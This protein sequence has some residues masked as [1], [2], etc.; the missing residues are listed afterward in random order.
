MRVKSK[1]KHNITL[2]YMNNTT[3]PFIVGVVELPKS[4]NGVVVLDE[5][6]KVLNMEEKSQGLKLYW[7]VPHFY[8]YQ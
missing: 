8:I 7:V 3:L 4:K 1:E 6:N 2:N 5:N